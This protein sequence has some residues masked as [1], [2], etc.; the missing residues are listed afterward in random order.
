MKRENIITAAVWIIGLV[1]LFYFAGS[2][3]KKT[4]V[5][6]PLAVPDENDKPQIG[7]YQLH[8]N[9]NPPIIFDTA[10]ADMWAGKDGKWT[11][12][13]SPVIAEKDLEFS[14]LVKNIQNSQTNKQPPKP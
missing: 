12:I 4:S 9:G 6:D 1:C 2:C 13:P 8:D 3:S 5:E 7:R 14:N 11:K 10:T